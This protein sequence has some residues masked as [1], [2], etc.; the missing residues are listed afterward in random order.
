MKRRDF[1][2][3]SALGG[4]ALLVGERA[5][6]MGDPDKFRIAQIVYA[7]GNPKPRPTGLRRILWEIDKRTSIDVKLDPVEVRVA[8]PELFRFP[9]LYLAGD[10]AFPPPPDDDVARLRRHLASGGFLLVDAAEGKPGSGFDQ[11]VRALA[12]RL[13]PKEPLDRLSEEHVLYKS[14]YLLHV[15]VGRVLAVPYLEAVTHDGRA[16]LVY[17]QNDLAG[18]WA[19]DELGQWEH[20]VHPGGEQQREMAFRLGVNLA[21]YAT[22]LDYKTDQV[23]VPFILRRRRW[24]AEPQ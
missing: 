8:Q 19:R 14:F 15:P 22:C 24:N 23:H 1:L 6:A 10:R 4:A 5:R 17:C 20:E 7:G 11:S 2:R 12:A 3:A 16:A 21:M 13:F 18:A 9:F